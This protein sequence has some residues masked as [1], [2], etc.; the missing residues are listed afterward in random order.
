MLQ[1]A[2]GVEEHKGLDAAQIE[3]GT[4]ASPEVIA[5]AEATVASTKWTT[6][7]SRAPLGSGV[8]ATRHNLFRSES[9]ATF[10]HIRINYHPDG[11]VARVRAFGE[12][13]PDFEKMAVA[14]ASG[15]ILTDLSSQ[16]NGGKWWQ[17]RWWQWLW[18][19]QESVTLDIS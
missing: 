13:R 7:V 3:V 2:N 4:C 12:P 1:G 17:W 15:G 14:A 8:E 18:W 11:G 19:Q 10:T 16:R 6:L 5:A 9:D